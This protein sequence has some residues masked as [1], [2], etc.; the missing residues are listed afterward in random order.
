MVGQK[1]ARKAAGVIL[2][3]IKEGKIA[4]RAVLISGYFIINKKT[5]FYRKNSNCIGN[6]T[7]IRKG[8]TFY[9]FK[10]VRNILNGD[11]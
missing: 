2:K 10:C 6:V 7:R 1:S 11:E 9:K 8:N 4:G 3:M 5:T